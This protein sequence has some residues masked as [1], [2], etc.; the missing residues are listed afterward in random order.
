[1]LKTSLRHAP[2]FLV[3]VL[4]SVT[5]C[6]ILLWDH[7]LTFED[8]IK[9]IWKRPVEL[10]KAVFLFNRYFVEGVVCLSAYGELEHFLERGGE[11]LTWG[12]QYF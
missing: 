1:M 10:T 12:L 9:Y 8:E 5:G 7:L 2:V 3:D 6:A 4:V 11:D